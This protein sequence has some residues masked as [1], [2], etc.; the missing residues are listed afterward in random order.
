MKTHALSLAVLLACAAA[1]PA[2]AQSAN[3]DPAKVEAGTYTVE[4]NHTQVM[5]TVSH[6]GFSNYTGSFTGASGDLTLDP[7]TASASA[8]KVSVP[9]ASVMTPSAKLVDELKS[10]DWLDAGKYPTMTFV[11]TK[12]TPLG[13]GRAK[14]TGDLTIHGTTKPATLDVTFVGAGT[15]P[16]D[17]K[18]T[19]GFE[20]KGDI[21]R[22][23]FGV[24]K[25][26]PLIGDTLHLTIAGAFERQ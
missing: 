24:S 6:M 4:P 5:F 9:V 20:A 13:K 25:Y 7:K 10:A 22:S 16:L 26:V 11:S 18:Y 3:H 14:V 21:K 15:N 19:V 1:V 23:E 2:G 12:V 8:L 17:K